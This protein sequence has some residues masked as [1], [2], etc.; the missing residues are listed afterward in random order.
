MRPGPLQFRRRK[1]AL[2]ACKE[3]NPASRRRG[4]LAEQPGQGLRILSLPCQKRRSAACGLTNRV[5]KVQWNV[6]PAQPAPARLLACGQNDFPPALQFSHSGSGCRTHDGM[7]VKN[8][9]KSLHPD[10]SPLFQYPFQPIV[11]ENG[12]VK[13]NP[14][15]RIFFLFRFL[16]QPSR[17][18]VFPNRLNP[19]GISASI[20]VKKPHSV[21]GTFTQY[22]GYVP[23]FCT[24]QSEPPARKRAWGKIKGRWWGH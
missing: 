4:S 1:T 24:A 6:H 12:R 13:M 9:G 8:G 21:P 15:R 16:Y 18:L 7:F 19:T 17:H 11:F 10:F 20:A 5:L 14:I 3:M 22:S 23:R 2:R